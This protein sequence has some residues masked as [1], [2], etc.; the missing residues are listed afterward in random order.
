MYLHTN[1][2]PYLHVHVCHTMKCKY[3]SVFDKYM[4]HHWPKELLIWH[5]TVLFLGQWNS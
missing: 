1:T 4:A 2:C 5:C 3:I